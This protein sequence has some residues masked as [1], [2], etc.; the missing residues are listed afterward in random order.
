MTAPG[1]NICRTTNGAQ[2]V[3]NGTLVSWP[4]I[5]RPHL[6]DAHAATTSW[7]RH[8]EQ[9]W[10]RTRSR[11]TGRILTMVAQPV[12]FL[13]IAALLIAASASSCLSVKLVRSHQDPDA[14]RS[15][16]E[17]HGSGLIA[18]QPGVAATGD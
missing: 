17:C 15:D 8:I 13:S 18:Q 4:G 16:V 11:C 12:S 10:S 9:T 1:R 2:F 7:Q 6:R 14:T 5:H 3:L